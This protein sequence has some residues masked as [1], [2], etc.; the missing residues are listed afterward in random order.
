MER[1][2]ND[3]TKLAMDRNVSF[4]KREMG[5]KIL[6]SFIIKVNDHFVGSY[7]TS[8]VG[9]D[10][11]AMGEKVKHV[12]IDFDDFE[13]LLKI[14]KEGIK[15]F[16]FK[17]YDKILDDD[18]RIPI[19][20]PEGEFG[21]G[22]MG[23]VF[24]GKIQPVNDGIHT[25][26]FNEPVVEKW[27]DLE[28]LEFNKNSEWAKRIMKCLKFFVS[29]GKGEYAI[30][31]FNIYDG[32]DFVISMRGSTQG[33]VDLIDNPPGLEKLYELGYK[34]GAKFFDMRKE[35]VKRYNES[36]LMHKEYSDLAPIHSVPILDMDAYALCSKEI[37]EKI[38][39]KYKQKI[40]NYTRGGR[41]YIH[42]QGYFIIPIAANLDNLTEVFL[43]DDPGFPKAFSSR[44]EFRKT[45]L[46]IPLCMFCKFEDFKKALEDKSLSGGTKYYIF[47]EDSTINTYD[48]NILMDKVRNYRTT[49]FAAK[50]K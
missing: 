41:F 2:L 27:S 8:D 28:E 23:A 35:V 3:R 10:G 49:K 48:L 1:R 11:I 25:Y 20:Y 36:V 44:L 26:S 37:F 17:N 19:I 5:N 13:R 47:V 32:A 29:N 24:G 16:K 30:Q 34:T 22:Q 14:Y 6:A 39:F 31:L 45:M 38:G 4:W 50:G 21:C 33:F 15:L 40:L 7:V 12:N 43:F 9:P 46:D 18:I 42:G